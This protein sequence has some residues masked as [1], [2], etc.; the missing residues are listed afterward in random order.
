MAK[1]RVMVVEDEAVTATV[2]KRSLT[3]LGYEITALV[4]SGEDAVKK[5]EEDMPDL[6][7][8]DILLSGKMDGT[9]AAGRITSSFGIPSIYLT[10]YSD[11]ETVNRAKLA[12]PYGYLVKPF[13]DRELSSTIEVALY[14][15]DM[16][17]KLS[18]QLDTTKRMNKLFVDRELKM[19]ELRKEN[20]QLKKRLEEPE[21]GKGG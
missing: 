2:I 12:E 17:K 6:V 8:M 18:E 16:E 4:S 19:E 11:E 14:K 13:N 1:A 3:D 15:H 21:D 7:L 10:G 20:T 9:E 5:A